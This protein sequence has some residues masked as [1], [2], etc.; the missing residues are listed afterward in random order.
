MFAV[1]DAT[2][3]Q[4]PVTRTQYDVDFVSAGVL[5]S[6]APAETS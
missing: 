1:C 4:R 2:T 6:M 5:Y 3:P